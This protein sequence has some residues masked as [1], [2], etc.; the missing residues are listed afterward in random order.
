MK[1]GPLCK[2][3]TGNMMALGKIE[4][5][6]TSDFKD[7]WFIILDFSLKTIF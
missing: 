2:C 5:G 3:D 6:V 4:N 1:L 7:A